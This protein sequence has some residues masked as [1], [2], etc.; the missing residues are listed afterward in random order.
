MGARL[1]R[2]KHPELSN[3]Q[4]SRTQVKKKKREHRAPISA[5]HSRG[6]KKAQRLEKRP[7]QIWQTTPL[8]KA[9]TWEESQQHSLLRSG[10]QNK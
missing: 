1:R 6:K 8:R 3:T 5:A 7:N 4:H 9:N 10:R 2:E